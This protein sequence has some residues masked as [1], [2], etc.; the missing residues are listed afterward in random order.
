[1]CQRWAE[2]KV[3]RRRKRFRQTNPCATAAC[4]EIV[5]EA[6]KTWS[7]NQAFSEN[8]LTDVSDGVQQAFELFAAIPEAFK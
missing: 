1:M 3:G 6:H 2:E 8:P 5:Y 7:W 4:P